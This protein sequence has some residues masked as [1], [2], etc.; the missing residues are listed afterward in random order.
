MRWVSA[1][2]I[3]LIGL[4]LVYWAQQLSIRYNGWTTRLRQEHPR[5]DPPP[6]PEMRALNTK[7]MTW[8]F[9]VLGVCLLL[10]SVVAFFGAWGS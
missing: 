9:R 3:N 7:I 1:L 6:T 4:A 5:I 8:I 10:L 2:I